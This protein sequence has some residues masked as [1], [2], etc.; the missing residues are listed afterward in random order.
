M[1]RIFFITILF[2]LFLIPCLAQN[3]TD[4]VKKIGELKPFIKKDYEGWH[5]VKSNFFTFYVPTSLMEKKVK[6][7]EGGCY[8]FENENL[9]LN[10]DINYDAGYPT[11]EKQY[12]SYSEKFVYID[13]ALVWIWSFDHTGIYKYESSGL[14]QFKKKDRDYR[15]GMYLFSKD[16]DIKEIAEMIFKS[17]QF[18]DNQK[19]R[20]LLKNI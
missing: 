11:F 14:F 6:C 13:N 8:T 9:S 19:K 17:V 12:P 16:K 4:S 5:K 15:F 1:K 7:I 2:A 10:I 18:K 3:K 20:K